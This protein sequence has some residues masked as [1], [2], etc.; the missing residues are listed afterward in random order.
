MI[1]TTI[2]TQ[3]HSYDDIEVGSTFQGFGRTITE[4]EIVMI[5]AM[6][7]GFHQPLH[8]NSQWVAEN[9]QFPGVLLPG[10]VIISYAIGQLSSTLIYSTITIAMVGIDKVRAI[11]PVCAGDTINARATVVLKRRT[12]ASDR[13][14]LELA[15]EVFNQSGA[16]VMTFDYVLMVRA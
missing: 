6:T 2:A 11:K 14:I 12:S 1:S 7:T 8:T 16:V 10:A 4:A 15:V 5:T 9:T 3:W 13:G